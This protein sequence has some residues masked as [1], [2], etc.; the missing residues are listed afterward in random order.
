LSTIRI[1]VALKLRR[2]Q[3]GIAPDCWL[4][5]IDTARFMDE[6]VYPSLIMSFNCL[7]PR[8]H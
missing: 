6:P 5:L 7:V 2:R 1:R 4:Y 3:N 8:L